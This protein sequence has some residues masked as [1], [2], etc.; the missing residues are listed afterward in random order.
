MKTC[1]FKP[2]PA[3]SAIFGAQPQTAPSNACTPTCAIFV[4]LGPQAGM[5]ALLMGG[6]ACHNLAISTGAL[7]QKLAPDET[8]ASNPVNDPA[9]RA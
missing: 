7:A 9:S 5:C 6:I 1:P 3:A 8:A 2:A 4:A